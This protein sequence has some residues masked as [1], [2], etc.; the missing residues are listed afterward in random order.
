MSFGNNS[1]LCLYPGGLDISSCLRDADINSHPILVEGWGP[2]PVTVL[3]KG[4]RFS[5]GNSPWSSSLCLHICTDTQRCCEQG[6][7]MAWT[8]QKCLLTILGGTFPPHNSQPSSTS[9]DL[10]TCWSPAGQQDSEGKTAPTSFW[11]R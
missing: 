3:F 10:L 9:W 6:F 1:I 2:V 11:S 5:R 4:S 8:K 7:W